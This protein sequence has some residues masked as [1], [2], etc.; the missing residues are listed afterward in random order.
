VITVITVD[1]PNLG[2]YPYVTRSLPP[3]EPDMY[4]HV[5]ICSLYSYLSSSQ[6]YWGLL[7]VAQLGAHH[8]IPLSPTFIINLSFDMS[9]TPG[10]HH[11]PSQ[12]FKT[13]RR[14]CGLAF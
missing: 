10:H 2:N 3:P 8:V 12:A 14:R 9:D 11:Y 6:L 4:R 1:E 13:Q 7:V 5:G